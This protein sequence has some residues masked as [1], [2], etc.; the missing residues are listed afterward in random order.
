MGFKL[1]FGSGP[2]GILEPCAGSKLGNRVLLQHATVQYNGSGMAA[3]V[4]GVSGIPEMTGTVHVFDYM[5]SPPQFPSASVC[6]VFGDESFL[7]RLALKTLR[8]QVLD[9]ADAPFA[10]FD[11]ESAEWRDVLDELST[12]ALFGG[13]GKRLAIVEQ[14]DG[15]VTKHRDRLE[16]YVEKPR[17]SG[18]LILEVG[19]WAGNTRLYKAIDKTGLQ[20][21]CRAPQRAAG[22]SKFLDER[23]IAAWLSHWSETRHGA[24][25]NPQAATLLLELVG[26]EFGILDQDLAKLALF[27]EPGGVIKPELVRDVVGGWK[28]KTI[29]ELMDAACDGNAGEALLQLDRA[30]QSG[31]PPQALFGQISWSLRRFAAATRIFERAERGGRR[32]PLRAALEQ[33]GFRPYPK[34]ALE[35][36]ER[37]LKQLGRER[38]GQLYRW[39]LEA[40]LA[41]KGTHSAP[42]RARSILEQLI[43]RLAKDAAPQ[44]AGRA[45]T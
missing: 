1:P 4:D 42:D 8:N 11:G 16:A 2:D 39:L 10:T 26:P 41:L 37:Q 14:A 40:D 38:A 35:N 29:W 45:S 28:T 32:L 15:F 22:R 34:N 13:G 6:V 9:D 25:L 31:E 21:E 27:V 36:A 23:R 30:L 20:I 44:P 3:R 7:K 12:V 19:T 17:S 33:A 24:R 18:V 43:L 5:E